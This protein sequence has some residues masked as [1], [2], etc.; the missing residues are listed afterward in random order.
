V[1]FGSLTPEQGTAALGLLLD[2]G[3]AEA[4]VV[5]FDA[6]RWAEAHPSA[7]RAPYFSALLTSASPAPSKGYDAALT[8]RELLAAPAADRGAMVEAYLGRLVGR[9]LR[10]GDRKLDGDRSFFSLG[11]DS[12]MALEL[13][14]RLDADLGVALAPVKFLETPTVASLARLVLEQLPEAATAVPSPDEVESLSD[15]AMDALLQQML[16][17]RPSH[18]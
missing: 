7:A 15:E 9:L 2:A 10:L 5:P 14:G 11:F 17:R 12:L 8:R 1:G 18:S 3:V 4:G 13:R 6:P 16:A